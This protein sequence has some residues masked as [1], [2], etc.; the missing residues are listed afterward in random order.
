MLNK[1]KMFQIGL[2]GAGNIGFPIAK[3][4]LKKGNGL[5][6]FNRTKEKLIPLVKDGAQECKDVAGLFQSCTVVLI[7]L[8]DYAAI[9]STIPFDTL[10]KSGKR[11]KNQIV[12]N[13]STIAPEESKLL[14]AEFAQCEINYLEAPVSGGPL[15]AT[16]GLLGTIVSGN[17]PL[18]EEYKELFNVY[19]RDIFYAGPLGNA[20]TLK[21]VNNLMETINLIGASEALVIL[22][23]AGI[24]AAS[25]HPVLSKMRGH[26]VYMDLLFERRIKNDQRVYATSKLRL[27]D[28]YLAGELIDKYFV[29]AQLGNYCIE[30]FQNVI[31]ISGADVDQTTCYNVIAN[32]Q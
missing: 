3:V 19:C 27:K 29:D 11:N 15:K 2:I 12:I 5:S 22:E 14:A 21:I 1:T 16:D 8:S 6:V 31:E 20:L 24:D 30:H 7:C 26:S 4:F 10:R 13:I 9:M 17:K 25:A 28:L 32:R 23:R 18:F